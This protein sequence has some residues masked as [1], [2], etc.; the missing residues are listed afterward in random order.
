[1]PTSTLYRRAFGEVE[2]LLER[3]AD[4]LRAG[5]WIARPSKRRQS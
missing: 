1:M 5:G 4:V 3:F 2:P